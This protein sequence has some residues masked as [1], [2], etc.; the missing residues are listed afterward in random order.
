VT[1][2]RLSI[3]IDLANRRAIGPGKI[4]LLE[5]VGESGSISAA[6][7]ALELLRISSQSAAQI[8]GSSVIDN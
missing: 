8:E 6:G 2:A 5:L 1:V 7:R 4:R 3:R